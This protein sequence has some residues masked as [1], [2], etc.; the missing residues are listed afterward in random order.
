MAA[1]QFSTQMMIVC[2]EQ[3]PV[4]FGSDAPRSSKIGSLDYEPRIKSKLE[5]GIGFLS[6]KVLSP[7]HKSAPSPELPPSFSIFQINVLAVQRN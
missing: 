6:V 3:T 1:K 7:N 2:I 5:F 4:S